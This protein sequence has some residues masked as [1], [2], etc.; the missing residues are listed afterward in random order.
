MVTRVRAL[1][2][3]GMRGSTHVTVRRVAI[4]PW[5]PVVHRAGPVARYDRHDGSIRHDFD[6]ILAVTWGL[7]QT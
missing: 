6:S 5:I 2:L 4:G 1:V 7:R 3:P